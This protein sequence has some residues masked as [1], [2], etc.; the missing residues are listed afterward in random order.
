MVL[1]DTSAW[2]WSRKPAH[3]ELR[4]A[5]D[6]RLE[7]DEIAICDMVSL[8]LLYSARS[9][10]EFDRRRDELSALRQCPIAEPQFRRALDVMRKLAHRSA[11]EH[12]AVKFQDLLIA[13]GAEASSLPV[14]HYDEDYER[15]AAVTGQ[16]IEWLAP[17]AS[18]Q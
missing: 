4:A 11:L 12:R 8:E 2:V 6:E 17:K 3:S 13:C 9:A 16:P 15:I 1:A 14:L 5:F 7:N 10:G 18:L